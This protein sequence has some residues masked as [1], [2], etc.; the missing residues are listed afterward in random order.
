MRGDI[1]L[2]QKEAKRVYV[3]EQLLAGNLTI[4]QGALLLALSERQV[5]RLKAGVKQQGIAFLAHKNRGRK[6]KHAISDEVRQQVISLAACDY[7]GASCQH[8]SKLMAERDSITLS[9]RSI[10][11]VLN[12]AGM[13]N[14]HS[15]RTPK[16]RRSRE[17]MPREGMLV[18][19]DASLFAW[20]EDRGPLC[21][22]HGAID[23]ATGKILALH[24]RP[25][26]DSYGYLT[27]LW[28]L[29]TSYGVPHS[30]YS[31]RHTI[32]F[33]PKS[34]KLSIEEEL[35]GKKAPLTQFGRALE[36]L[37][38]CHIP[39]R[40]PQ[41]KG[42]V[43]RLWN[44]LQH[45]LVIELRL[46]NISTLEEANSFLDGFINRF[47]EE[48]SVQASA[49]EL[50]YSPA[51]DV[52]KLRAII[53]FKEQRKASNGSTISYHSKI[54]QLVDAK[55]AVTPLIPKKTVSI[56]SYLDG[57]IE[58]LYQ[59]QVYRLIQCDAPPSVP[60]TPPPTS[61]RRI[62]IPGPDHPWRRPFKRIAACRSAEKQNAKSPNTA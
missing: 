47:N 24:F 2:S 28:K 61:P 27:L 35:A 25:T 31:D 6:P 11:R 15:I 52:S 39:A 18:Q 44:T 41:A 10:R 58:A 17:R 22:L 48:F 29:V 16:R 40:S 62:N 42:R 4:K 14:T 8:M 26:E 43:E 12:Q 3:V 13:T 9:A 45:R 5:K 57:S 56:L 38:I 33:S 21:T 59:D 7:K 49:P 53:C 19:I 54:Y 36:E 1:L 50:A 23:D 32:F 51:P 37:G 46:A 34:E 55:G 30:I 20:L 60:K